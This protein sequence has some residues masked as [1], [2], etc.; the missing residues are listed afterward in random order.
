MKA[1]IPAKCNSTRVPNKNWRP[2]HKNVSLVELK[3]IQLINA[4]MLSSDI[5]VF[6]E[7]EIHREK[8]EILGA[9][10]ILR[11]FETTQDDMHWSDVVTNLVSNLDCDD[12][13]SIAWI[14]TPTPLF[15]SQNIKKVFDKWDEILVGSEND[16][17]ITVKPFNKFILN[18]KGKPVNFNF[19]RWHEWSQDLPKWYILEG[20]VNIM[21]KKTYLRCN[22]HI[23]ERPYL[24]EIPMSSIDIDDMG[25]FEMAQKIYDELFDNSSKI[26]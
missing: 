16:S 17:L 13:E 10:F 9:K 3:I 25:E 15:D 4:G 7:Q 6:C 12:E 18:E 20:P 8:V 2:F 19:G 11:D 22:Y 24:Y 23:G 14:Q 21:K 5:N 26:S 1:I